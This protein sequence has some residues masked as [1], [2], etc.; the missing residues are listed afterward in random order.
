MEST[1]NLMPL[2]R[3]S[4]NRWRDALPGRIL[5][6]KKITYKEYQNILKPA[7][8]DEKCFNYLL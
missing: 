7:Y 2:S 4:N 8:I 1:A 6:Q 5:V 3:R